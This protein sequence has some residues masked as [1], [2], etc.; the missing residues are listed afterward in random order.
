MS[1][2]GKRWAEGYRPKHGER[3]T[4]VLDPLE[5]TEAIAEKSFDAGYRAGLLR[6]VTLTLAEEAQRALHALGVDVREE[7]S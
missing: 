2:A 1:E 7:T 4:L 5:W 3:F 6:A